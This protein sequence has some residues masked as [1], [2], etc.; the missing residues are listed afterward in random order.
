[1]PGIEKPSGAIVAL[2]EPK[3]GYWDAAV[4]LVAGE[5]VKL[6]S[7]TAV[8]QAGASDVNAIGVVDRDL[9]K[10]KTDSYAINDLVPVRL[11][12]HVVEMIASAAISVG[13]RVETAAS[14]RIRTY[15]V[16]AVATD[17]EAEVIGVALQAASA[18]G[19][20]ILVLVRG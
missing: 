12:G 14:G 9:R 4:A 2:G 19:D 11:F 7:A 3:V 16:P 5:V 10:A 1:M 20:R 8:T 6:S 18:N 17:T 13:V 15:V